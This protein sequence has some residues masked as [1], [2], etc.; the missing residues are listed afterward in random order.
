MGPTFLFLPRPRHIKGEMESWERSTA[1]WFFRSLHF[2]GLFGGML[3]Y[4]HSHRCSGYSTKGHSDH[5]WARGDGVNFP[6]HFHKIIPPMH[7]ALLTT[8]PSLFRKFYGHPPTK[9]K[10]S[11]KCH[12]IKNNSRC[13]RKLYCFGCV[14]WA[15]KISP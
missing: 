5:T 1:K 4:A 7:K 2:R 10:I 9:R 6:M 14:F 8:N 12:Q 13:A 11:S 15:R 3:Q